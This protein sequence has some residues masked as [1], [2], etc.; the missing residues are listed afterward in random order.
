MIKLRCLQLK[1]L[2]INLNYLFGTFLILSVGSFYL[3]APVLGLVVIALMWACL[4]S[5]FRGFEFDEIKESMLSLVVKGLPAFYIFIL[6]GILIAAFIE[7][8]TIATLVVYGLDILSVKYFLPLG[9]IIC[10]IMS[11]AT[12]TSWGTVATVGIVLMNIGQALHIPPALV[13]GMVISGASFG[14]KMSAVSDTTNLAAM[15]AGANLYDHIRG[16]LYTTLP[17]FILALII[18]SIFGSFYQAQ[19]LPHTEIYHLQHG[20]ADEFT[21]NSVTL[22]PLVLLVVAS[23]S[24]VSAE[25]SMGVSIIS[26][27]IIAGFFQHRGVQEIIN[28]IQW[29]Y[30]ATPKMSSLSPMLIRGGVSSM[31][32]IVA[33]SFLML[34]LGGL[35]HRTGILNQI[36]SAPLKKVKRASSLM[37]VSIASAVLFNLVVG[38]AYLSILLNG[39]LFRK[40]FKKTGLQARLLS[41]C[42]EEGATLSAGLI[43]WTTAGIFYATNLHIS[44]VDY[45]P[46][47]FLNY[48]NPIVS[49]VLAYLG[50]GIVREENRACKKTYD[51]LPD[52]IVRDLP[53]LFVDRVSENKQEFMRVDHVM[54][55]IA[56]HQH[57]R[58]DS[59]HLMP[60]DGTINRINIQSQTPEYCIFSGQWN[61]ATEENSSSANI[62]GGFGEL[63]I[64]THQMGI[65]IPGVTATRENLAYYGAQ[66]FKVGEVIN[67]SSDDNLPVMA[68]TISPE[69]VKEYIMDPH[70]GGGNYLEYHDRPHF[71]MPLDANAGGH[72]VLAKNVGD[73]YHIT[74]FNIPFGYG[75]LTPNGVIHNDAHL[76]GK[77]AVV[78]SIAEHYSTV[79]VKNKNHCLMNFTISD[80]LFVPCC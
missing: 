46:Y 73:A 60:T 13:A 44:V 10:S 61:T 62:L 80:K 69:Y 34:S 15:S 6:I 30:T 1:E 52:D 72:L 58:V 78:Y 71:H 74:G 54:G 3:H 51:N 11:L 66:L 12:G 50:F 59:D 63:M 14:D 48:I 18:F 42:T 25:V 20:L 27:F 39:E 21:I 57:Y 23:L 36:I 41:R 64:N 37:S 17:S 29:G 79:I 67:F 77:Y 47:A 76:I 24:R 28:S 56:P 9:L 45:L 7:S 49:I 31:M 53:V 4:F 75:V 38:E 19:S 16:M 8:G 35:L 5:Y 33:L 22:I 32:P 2:L 43:P 40:E 26:A 55:Y 65:E 68:M 70:K